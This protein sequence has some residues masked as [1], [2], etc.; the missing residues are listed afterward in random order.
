[1]RV[2]NNESFYIILHDVLQNVINL[3]NMHEIRR[4]SEL[5]YI[6]YVPDRLEKR[7]FAKR[8][9]KTVAERLHCIPRGR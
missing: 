7:G 6:R 4:F 3:V 1:M 8:R 9:Q 2:T 5:L